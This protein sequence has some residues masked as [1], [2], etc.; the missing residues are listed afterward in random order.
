MNENIL[1]GKNAQFL[2]VGQWQKALLQTDSLQAIYGDNPDVLK[3]RLKVVKRSL[4]AYAEAFDPKDR[5]CLIRCPSRIN[6]EGHHVDHQ[7]GCYNAT[8]EAHEVIVACSP[9]SDATVVIHNAENDRYPPVQFVLDTSGQLGWGRFPFGTW[10]AMSEEFSDEGSPGAKLAIASDI[11]SGSGMS[12]SHAIL[13]SSCLAFLAISGRELDKNRAV[14]LI[15]K[16]DWY[17]GARTGLGDQAAMLFGK[18]GFLFHSRM[19]CPE[20]IRP[21]YVPLPQEHEMVLI[22]SYTQHTL[23]GKEALGYNSRVFASRVGLPI[24]LYS[25]SKKGAAQKALEKVTKPADITPKTFDLKTIYSSLLA[26]PRELPL[27]ETRK[28]WSESASRLPVD[29]DFDQLLETYFADSPCPDS[30]HLRGV[31]LYTLAE[32]WRSHLYPRLLREKRIIEAGLLVNIGHDGD[33]RFVNKSGQYVPDEHPVTDENLQALLDMLEA[34][35]EKRRHCAK[36]QYQR[37][38]Y[39]A[40]VLE[41]DEIVDI[42][43]NCGATSA[44]LTGGGHG[45]VVAVMIPREYY[46]SLSNEIRYYYIKKRKLDQSR[47]ESGFQRCITVA[48]AGYVTI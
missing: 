37:G 26:I 16:A 14:G 4:E 13:V 17:A 27:D 2:P 42:A 3:N 41:L 29:L 6:W 24:L 22:D 32:C 19:G 8:T 33:R 7:G 34:E 47:A 44:S 39:G 23:T 5:V 40:S 11:P 10:K 28:K 20:D 35:D 45:G 30:I 1:N 43:R 38:D 31:M 9:S 36:L 48:A 18:R 21:E 25:M 15:Q 12:S 46:D